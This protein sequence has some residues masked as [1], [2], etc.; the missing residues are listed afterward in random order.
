MTEATPINLIAL[1]EQEIA[2]YQRNVDMY[3][4]ILADLPTEWPSRL[5]QY[6][7][8]ENRHNSIAEVEDLADV[9]LLSNLWYADD[10][11]RFIRTE[12]LEMTKSKAILKALEAQA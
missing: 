7:N 2:D 8:V 3:T 11:H 1:R 5:E 4:A 10:C 9:E 6:R 12:T